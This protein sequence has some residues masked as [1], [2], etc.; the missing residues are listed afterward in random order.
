MP[1]VHMGKRLP[2]ARTARP[3][4]RHAPYLGKR[5]AERG[6]AQFPRNPCCRSAEYECLDSL[7]VLRNR[8]DELQQQLHMPLHR[9]AHIQHHQ[10]A[11]CSRHAPLARQ[12]HRV[13]ATTHVQPHRPAQ[14]RAALAPVP[15]APP[16]RTR[17]HRSYHPRCNAR[18]LRK[19]VRAQ[20]AEVGRSRSSAAARARPQHLHQ[21]ILR[22]SV[23][24]RHHCYA[25]RAP[26][27]ARAA[28]EVVL[29]I[30][31]G[32]QRQLLEVPEALE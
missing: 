21:S 8:E 22:R 15:L 31:V 5:L 24:F 26:E 25:R 32:T 18:Q 19:L 11:R 14:V 29:G 28:Y 30:D 27:L 16:A 23:I 13:A 17:R 20:H 3:V 7:R 2:Y 1:R 6:R 12:H 4:P 9:A 10:Q